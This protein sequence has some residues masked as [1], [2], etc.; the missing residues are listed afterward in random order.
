MLT[1]RSGFIKQGPGKLFKSDSEISAYRMKHQEEYFIVSQMDNIIDLVT[2]FF[3]F[4]F[5]LYKDQEARQYP[6]T[7]LEGVP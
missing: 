3:S 1:P 7:L 5:F 4:L 2:F 6:L